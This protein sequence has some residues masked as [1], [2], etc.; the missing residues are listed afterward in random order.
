MPKRVISTDKVVKPL[1]P[2]S[3]A[4]MANGFVFTQGILGRDPSGKLLEGMEAQARQ[5]ME[6]LKGILEAAGG[7]LDDVLRAEVFVADLSEMPVFNEVWKEYFSENP[8]ARIGVEV[9]NLAA[10]ARVE[11]IAVAYVGEK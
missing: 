4:T 10:G 11:M 8:P 2:I 9:P 3:Q 5:V 6:N 1:S 7:T